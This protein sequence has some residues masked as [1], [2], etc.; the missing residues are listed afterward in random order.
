MSL[1]DVHVK[2][3]AGVP[4]D[5]AI[6]ADILSTHASPPETS[7]SLDYVYRHAELRWYNA[8]VLVC[9]HCAVKHK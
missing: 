9:V 1:Q 5:L 8:H 4:F 7:G 3:V 2:L 6:R